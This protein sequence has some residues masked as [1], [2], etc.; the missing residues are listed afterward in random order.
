MVQ[1][2]G[3]ALCACFTKD[4]RHKRIPTF[5][6]NASE[7]VMFAYF[8]GIA[9]GRT[10]HTPS[11]ESIVLRASALRWDWSFFRTGYHFRLKVSA[12]K[13]YHIRYLTS[14]DQT[15]EHRQESD[16]PGTSS[17]TRTWPT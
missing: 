10:V 3:L 15:S 12:S 16:P 9:D 1:T 4:G 7:N 8:Q 5:V 11:N 14:S 17:P 13:K 2:C 6:L